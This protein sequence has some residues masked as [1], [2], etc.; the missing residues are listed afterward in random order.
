[1]H[2]MHIYR[3]NLYLCAKDDKQLIAILSKEIYFLI[4]YICMYLKN[5]K[6]IKK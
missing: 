3:R 5:L 1:M 6:K 4:Y 2:G